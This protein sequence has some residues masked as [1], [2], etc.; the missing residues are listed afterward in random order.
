MFSLIPDD[1]D[2]DLDLAMKIVV[3]QVKRETNMIPNN[4]HEYHSRLNVELAE[5]F[6]SQTMMNLLNY[7]HILL[8]NFL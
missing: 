3:K 2:D 1:N 6:T 5:E 7:A 4:K 8:Q